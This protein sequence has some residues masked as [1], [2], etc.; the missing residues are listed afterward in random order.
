[1]RIPAHLGLVY[2]ARYQQS[3]D[4]IVLH[5]MGQDGR[6]NERLSS[7]H[8]QIFHYSFLAGSGRIEDAE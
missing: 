5:E 8:K 6:A 4:L 2:A 7:Q 3:L 1:M